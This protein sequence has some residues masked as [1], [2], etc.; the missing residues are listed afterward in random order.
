MLVSEPENREV[1]VQTMSFNC[2]AALD[3]PESS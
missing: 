1:L 3:I 2:R